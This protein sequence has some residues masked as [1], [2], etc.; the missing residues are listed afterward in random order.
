MKKLHILFVMV[1]V[2]ILISCEKDD[3]SLSI[4]H[5][6]GVEGYYPKAINV[7]ALCYDDSGA[8]IYPGP[9]KV[10]PINFWFT[11][12]SPVKRVD[13]LGKV[14][15][16]VSSSERYTDLQ[17]IKSYNYD[18]S[19]RNLHPTAA[20]DTLRLEWDLPD[21]ALSPKK[22]VYYKIA[23]VC[24]NELADTTSGDYWSLK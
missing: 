17:L 21:V 7:G 11:S 14:D 24:E 19:N 15:V 12:E 23:V 2:G 18:I 22:Y 4:P 3:N 8:K 10:F 9:N 5:K 1:F 13:L 16:K 20:I 6:D